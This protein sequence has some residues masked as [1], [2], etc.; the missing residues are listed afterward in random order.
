[1]DD[2]RR[3]VPDRGVAGRGAVGGERAGGDAKS[4]SP[5][6][7]DLI[8]KLQK[9]V[10]IEKAIDNVPLRDVIELFNDRYDVGLRI[11]S[12]AFD[13]DKGVKGIKDAPVRLTKAAGIRLNDILHELLSQ[14]GGTFLVRGDHLEVTTFER[15]VAEVY[16]TRSMTVT[17]SASASRSS[18]S[19]ST[20]SRSAG[21]GRVVPPDWP[22]D[23][24]RPAR[25]RP[26][27]ARGHGPNAQRPARHGHALSGGDQR[28]E[29]GAAR[30]RVPGHHAQNAAKALQDEQDELARRARQGVQETEQRLQAAR[31]AAGVP[32]PEKPKP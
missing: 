17:P 25:R 29:G 21:A 10:D 12:L 20:T 27:Q 30:Q 14:I 18:T 15:M 32:A 31:A 19:P 7:V 2:S 16:G 6:S 11:D 26:R 3:L 5:R 1:M 22:H 23:H 8:E 13:Q 4:A 24:P 9:P 28:P